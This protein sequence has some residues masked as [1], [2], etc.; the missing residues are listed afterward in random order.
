MSK[1]E[2]HQPTYP[3]ACCP[4]CFAL[5]P[6]GETLPEAFVQRNC[7]LGRCPKQTVTIHDRSGLDAVRR[8]GRPAVPKSGPLVREE[9]KI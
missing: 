8:F 7:D 1:M 3:V 9:A 4:T 6:E 5:F 2:K